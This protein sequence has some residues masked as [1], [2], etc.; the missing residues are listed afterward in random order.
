[1]EEFEQLQK[2]KTIKTKKIMRKSTFAKIFDLTVI[3][4]FFVTIISSIVLL[5][6]WSKNNVNMSFYSTL[7]LALSSIVLL[8]CSI[9]SLLLYSPIIHTYQ[10]SRMFLLMIVTVCFGTIFGISCKILKEL[11]DLKNKS[12][13]ETNEMQNNKELKSLHYIAGLLIPCSIAII[14]LIAI[15]YKMFIKI[16]AQDVKFDEN[17]INVQ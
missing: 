6:G 17:A 9:G 10:K 16:F 14:L 4:C 8:L 3:P 13:E 2:L 1:M 15:V 12:N 11:Q 5:V 7:F